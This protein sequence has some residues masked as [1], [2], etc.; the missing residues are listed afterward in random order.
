MISFFVIQ[1]EKKKQIFKIQILTFLY[2]AIEKLTN[3]LLQIVLSIHVKSLIYP[4]QTK[5]DL[6]V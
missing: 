5:G 6:H 4:S 1:Q 2:F 3:N